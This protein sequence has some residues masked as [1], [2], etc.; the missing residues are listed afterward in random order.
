MMMSCM[1]LHRVAPALIL[2]VAFGSSA[3]FSQ[4]LF[5]RGGRVLTGTGQDMKDT[6]VLVR[7][8]RIAEVGPDLVA[9]SGVKT[10]NAYGRV[11]M[12]AY[13]VAHTSS[14]IGRSNEVAPVTPFVS[15]LDSLD[16]TAA[17]IEDCFRDGN[18]TLHICP[19][20][21]TVV[22]GTGAIVKPY[23]LSVNSMAMVPDASMK[24]SM[25]P[26]NG[27]RASQLA[28]LRQALEDGQRYLEGK[29]RDAESEV[30]TGNVALDLKALGV[31]RRQQSMARLL[32]G[33]LVAFVACETA[34]DCLQALKLAEEFKIKVRLVCGPGTWRAA[35]WLGKQGVS[36]ILEG[37][38][39]LEET[40]HETGKEVVRNIPSIM[41][42]A[43]VRFAVVP[44]P[45][46]LGTRYMWYQAA[47]LVRCGF[48]REEALACVT[49]IPAEMI[50]LKD[51]KGDLS[52]GKDADILILT[53]DP[54]SGL[55]WVDTG[56]VAGEV[57]Y[58]RSEDPRLAE[59]LG[60]EAK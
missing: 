30:K 43:G 22:G 57:I 42:K 52:V 51:R 46:G 9:P 17:F 33:D 1:K 13:V 44:E 39:L 36:I 2:L 18:Y 35:E 47:S 31:E 20:H 3:L 34:G 6:H 25:I 48:S 24:L 45:G 8:G 21:R 56:I 16:P 60:N 14:G 11:V 32:E 5:I 7:A 55:A 27:N 10:L 15:V 4:D 53:D 37:S 59:V 40:D 19:G 50:G 23:G 28:R 26:L 12:P 49:T 41:K 58:S 29:R 38:F 54:F